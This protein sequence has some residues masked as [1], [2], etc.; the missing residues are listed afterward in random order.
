MIAEN[1]HFLPFFL[2]EPI[3]LVP[4]ENQTKE[5]K[6]TEANK[7][8]VLPEL[9]PEADGPPKLPV[10]PY[11]GKN[12]KKVLLLFQNKKEEKLPKQEEL[13]LGKILHAVNL[14]FDDVALLN[15]ESVEEEAYPHLNH[16]DA[17]VWISFGVTH[18]NLIV[19]PTFPKYEI[20]K[21]ANGKCLLADPLEEIEKEKEK[22]VKLWNSLKLMFNK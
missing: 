10:L 3:Y 20:K 13:F 15:I 2:T 9:K 22:K 16:F 5:T 14:N 7:E 11:E 4:E 18:P 1:K 17:P 21:I 12:L 19:A 8:T 6:T